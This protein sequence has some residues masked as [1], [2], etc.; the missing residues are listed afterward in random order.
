MQAELKARL[1]GVAAE[2]FVLETSVFARRKL[3]SDGH[4]FF[5]RA[6]TSAR[7]F[8]IDW[9]RCNTERFRA[10]IVS[11]DADGAEGAAFE[12][13]EVRDVLLSHHRLI[14][15][16]YT[17]YCV[18]GDVHD[19]YAMGKAAFFDLL[20]A[21]QV[22]DGASESCAHPSPSCANPNPNPEPNP[23]PTPNPR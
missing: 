3:T 5:H 1:T 14:S 4:S 8:Q 16:V 7:G 19:G 18:A 21:M 23:N 10:L 6:S 13:A 17:Y 12:M 20:R 15:S 9:A 22:T 11:N 2:P